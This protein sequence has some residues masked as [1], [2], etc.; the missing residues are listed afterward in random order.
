[1]LCSVVFSYPMLCNRMHAIQSHAVLRCVL[2]CI[3]PLC[4][5]ACCMYVF[6]YACQSVCVSE[7]LCVYISIVCL[8]YVYQSVPPDIS[9]RRPNTS[10]H[11][12]LYP[13]VLF[14]L[15]LVWCWVLQPYVP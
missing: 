9:Q 14:I 10:K 3:V 6:M 15:L 8:A 1:M 7:S 13:P 2:L 12:T 5:S 11:Q 4:M